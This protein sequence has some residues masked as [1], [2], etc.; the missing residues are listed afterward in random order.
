MV[1]ICGGAFDLAD[2]Q[3]LKE[4]LNGALGAN[5]HKIKPQRKADKI[6]HLH[7]ISLQD[8]RTAKET[9][10]KQLVANHRLTVVVSWKDDAVLT[11]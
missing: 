8:L 6:V 5:R 3:R 11:V 10:N 1:N 4:M 7:F 2:L 9:L